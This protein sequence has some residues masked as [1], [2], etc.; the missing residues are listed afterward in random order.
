MLLC[1]VACI[2]T[3]VWGIGKGLYA[4]GSWVVST[5]SGWF[6]PAPPVPADPDADILELDYYS[7]DY[8][9]RQFPLGEL[10]KRRRVNFAR[11][12]NDVND[13]H[14]AAASRL[15]IPPQAN[16]E[17]L[18][19]LKHKM[20]HLRDTR[21][22]H[23]D[24]MTQSQPFLVPDAADFLTALG[25]RWQEY[26]GTHSRYIITSCTRT[27]ADVKKLR[28]VN[29]NSSENSAHRFGTTI[30]I[31]YNR[32][33]RRGKVYDGKL[34]EDL[35]RALYDMQQAGYCYVKYEHKQACFHIT[36]RPK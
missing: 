11:D 31:T 5:V 19:K 16:R 18:E 21:Y 20:V 24:R 8:R 27:D 26:H 15:G 13:T 10:N 29:V 1:V 14:L 35:A 34:K 3:A 36:V 22:Y 2:A 7:A 17:A 33:D 25:A 6:E 9:H 23:I 4:G 32:Y 28:R 12:F 30:D